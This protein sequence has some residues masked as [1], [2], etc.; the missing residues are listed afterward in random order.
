M[1]IRAD[2]SVEIGTG[3]VMRCM[4]LAQARKVAGE[5][6]TF[7]MAMPSPSLAERLQNSG[8]T[9]LY[10]HEPPGS[11]A[12]AAATA[13][14]TKETGND[15]I[16]VD[17]YHFSG[18]YQQRIKAAG[19]KLFFI[20]DF[21]HAKT[22]FADIVLNQNLSASDTY[23]QQK[24]DN[25]QL[26]LGCQYTMLRE[27]FWPWREGERIIAPRAKR[28]LVTMGGSDPDN[29]TLKVIQALSISQ[30]KDLEVI[31]IAGGS[32]PHLD[33]LKIASQSSSTAIEIIENTGGM[34]EL[35][36]W[37]DVSI[38]AGGGT[39]WEMAF[40]GLP[41]IIITI[42]DHQIETARRLHERGILYYHG[43]HRDCDVANISSA[44]EALCRDQLP[45]GFTR[46]SMSKQGRNLIDGYG[47][48]RVIRHMLPVQATQFRRTI[49]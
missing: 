27:E 25:T 14:I 35:M 3:H 41:G 42:E 9:V 19:L 45:G 47:V 21:G 11:A 31:V 44:I 26:L 22:Y 30:L 1:I 17:G 39:I 23:Y 32:N 48:E 10:H 37:A 46:T 29:V 38:T 20:D 15:W 5:T 16:I 49:L 4:A 34:P 8:F 18:D 28:I 6:A 12:D 2:A 13:R 7:L 33:S 40:M 43:F 24:Q 36:A